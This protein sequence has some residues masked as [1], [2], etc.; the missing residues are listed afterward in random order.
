[1]GSRVAEVFDRTTANDAVLVLDGYGLSLSVQRGTL[2]A[3]D[4][5]GEHRRTRIL[6]R[7]QRTVTRIV[8]LGSTGSVSLTALRWCTDTGIAVVVIDPADARIHAINTPVL[9]DDARLRRAQALAPLTDTAMTIACHLLT[10]RLGDQARITRTVLGQ[11]E[12][13]EAIERE[14][15]ALVAADSPD[16]AMVVEM[17][18][19]EQYWT[20]WRDAARRTFTTADR[21]RVPEHWTRFGGRSSPIGDAPTNR[22]AATPINAMLNYGIKLAEIEATIA[23][24]AL[25]LD[26]A[27]GVLH[28]DGLNRPALVLDLIEPARG[29]VEAMVLGWSTRRAFRKADFVELPSGE[30]RLLAPLS[31]EFTETL[32][33]LLRDRL[34]PVAEQVA[35][36]LS[37]LAPGVISV[38]TPLTRS[39]RKTSRATS[40]LAVRQTPRRTAPATTGGW[41]CPDCGAQVTNPQRIR[42][43]ACVAA[44]PT[45]SVEI[46]GRRGKA[47]AARRAQA[48]A[49]EAA[50]GAGTFD[51]TD[52]ARIQPQLV[53]VKLADIVAATGFSKSFASV[54]RAGKSRPH[55]SHWPSVGS[56]GTSLIAPSPPGASR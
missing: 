46:R 43:D 36:T 19:A 12:R 39:R 30:I 4:G 3:T 40:L 9:Y 49:W 52:W 34:A 5:I 27:L 21:R 10:L 55:P 1:M 32:L 26:P 22:H 29:T 28:A 18:A 56:P 14:L 54:V 44:D 31:H 6:H 15:I 47:I 20:S 17:R 45:N 11:P 50:G 42:C 24:R 37:D 2:V 38:P 23:C 7:A 16:A 53:A 13:A 25:G 35:A 41:S 8:M 33:P 51:P 48:A